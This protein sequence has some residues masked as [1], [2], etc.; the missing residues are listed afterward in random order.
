[1]SDDDP[2]HWHTL[3]VSILMTPEQADRMSRIATGDLRLAESITRI[4]GGTL[5]FA[6]WRLFD[7]HADPVPDI[8]PLVEHAQEEPCPEC[9]HHHAGPSLAGICIGCPCPV[10]RS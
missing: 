4:A 6:D 2:R 10:V 5:V 8:A 9:G 7:V 3:S 1:M